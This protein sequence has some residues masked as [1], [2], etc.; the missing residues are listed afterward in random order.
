MGLGVTFRLE[1]RDGTPHDPPTF[2]TG[3][4]VWRPGVPVR[5]RHRS[6]KVARLCQEAPFRGDPTIAPVWLIAV[7]AVESRR[8]GAAVSRSPR[9]SQRPLGTRHR[10]PRRSGRRRGGRPR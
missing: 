1:R 7:P 2:T 5:T 4:L 3:E 6:Y 10:V 8:P 9:R